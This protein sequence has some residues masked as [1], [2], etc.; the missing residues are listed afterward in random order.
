MARAKKPVAA[1]ATTQAP[2]GGPPAER[3]LTAPIARTGVLLRALVPIASSHYQ[4]AVGQLFE[5]DPRDAE[6]MVT[7]GH[8]ERA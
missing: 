8:A 3:P 4:V 1:D 5:A 2:P 7:K 6:R